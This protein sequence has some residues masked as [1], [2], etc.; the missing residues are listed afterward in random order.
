MAFDP[1]LQNK[2]WP[3]GETRILY[4]E[5]I[6]PRKTGTREDKSTWKVWGVTWNNSRYSYYPPDMILMDL[7]VL[8]ASSRS[9]AITRSVKD[10]KKGPVNVWYVAD[11]ATKEAPKVTNAQ[12]FEAELTKVDHQVMQNEKEMGIARA[13]AVKAAAEVVPKGTSPSE[14]LKYAETLLPWILGRTVKATP[15]D[16]AGI[17][18][19]PF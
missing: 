15:T 19:I 17:D 9:V 14:T 13:V 12:R 3:I 1:T 16:D 7:E 2:E 11:A 5:S 6:E 18:Q 10:G 4:F 8:L